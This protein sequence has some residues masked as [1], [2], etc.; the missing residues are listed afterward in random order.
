MKDRY[1]I[2]EFITGIERR[3]PVNNW[4]VDGVH[5]WPVIRIHLYFHLIRTLYAEKPEVERSASSGEGKL[6]R[7]GY[8]LLSVF[9][10]FRWLTTLPEKQ[11]LFVG[12][13][14]YR[15]NYRGKRFN[16][17]FDT[18]IEQQGIESKSIVFE[19]GLYARGE[20][21]NSHLITRY[22]PFLHG[23]TLFTRWFGGR[24]AA[25]ALDGIDEFADF[26]KQ[27]P[28]TAPFLYA[29]AD[30]IKTLAEEFGLKRR[31][32][33][34]VIARVKP[35]QAL[36][37]CYYTNNDEMA[38]V[39]AC[40]Q[41]G[42]Q[43]VE[44]QHG[45]QADIHMGYS[46]WTVVPAES[47]AVMPKIF[48]CWDEHSAKSI[49]SWA[50]NT[51]VEVIVTGNPWINYWKSKLLSKAD[52]KY[53]L[54]TLQP[55]PVTLEALFADNILKL[56][57]EEGY[58]WI[59]RLHPRQTKEVDQVMAYLREKGVADDVEVDAR[60]E[61]SLPELLS[62]ATLHV[63]HFSGSAIEAAMFDVPTV[64]FS[65]YAESGFKYLIQEGKAVF[66]DPA[67]PDFATRFA[68]YLANV[69]GESATFSPS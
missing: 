48:W 67:K 60:F 11:Y 32:F 40:N 2:R 41:A 13:D 36:F 5:L 49:A 65:A 19:F 8:D 4:K 24:K 21:H 68:A 1:D 53:I 51:P 30:R 39:A 43:T 69:S 33:S 42:I 17:F 3:F 35:Q 15:E 23:F 64:F 62:G 31:F 29:G 45:P 25:V 12:F 37:L 59:L 52:D 38:L 50:A 10:Y 58:R 66:L 47:Y 44:M 28:E 20:E 34:K 61:R 18:Y 54:Y 63:T 27:T 7:M 16:K 55:F 46:N 56:F 14:S 22:H 6:R 9:R 26:L 57:K